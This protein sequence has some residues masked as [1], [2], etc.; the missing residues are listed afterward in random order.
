MREACGVKT[1]P[2]NRCRSNAG[3]VL[4]VRSRSDWI[5]YLFGI[6]ANISFI[7]DDAKGANLFKVN[8]IRSKRLFLC[9]CI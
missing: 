2:S 5:F 3:S 7:G 1:R 6:Y 8:T 9:E 4:L